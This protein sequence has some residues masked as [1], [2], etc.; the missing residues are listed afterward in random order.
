MFS[1]IFAQGLF[2]FFHMSGFFCHGNNKSCPDLLS[3]K[4]SDIFTTRPGTLTTRRTRPG[5]F[6]VIITADASNNRWIKAIGAGVLES[7]QLKSQ[8]TCGKNKP[9]YYLFFS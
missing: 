8:S 9:H 6:D 1:S 2:I 3:I 7:N 5:T 4:T